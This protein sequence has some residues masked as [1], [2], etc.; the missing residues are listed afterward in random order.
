MDEAV[1]RIDFENPRLEY[2]A[3]NP[4]KG[5]IKIVSEQEIG[6]YGI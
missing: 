2:D 4:I 3:H 1:M 6:S 5:V